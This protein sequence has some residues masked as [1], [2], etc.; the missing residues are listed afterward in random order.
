MTFPHSHLWL[1]YAYAVEAWMHIYCFFLHIGWYCMYNIMYI[2]YAAVTLG[3][4]SWGLAGSA[5]VATS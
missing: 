4:V 3:T 5:E 1:Q 2:S